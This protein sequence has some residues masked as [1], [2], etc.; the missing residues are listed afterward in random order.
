MKNAKSLTLRLLAMVLAAIC[1]LMVGCKPS[2]KA[3]LEEVYNK[4]V[5]SASAAVKL[6][7]TISSDGTYVT[8]DSNPLNSDDY[9]VPG[10]YDAL[11]LFKTEME[12]PEY[13]DE[14]I[15]ST[16]WSMGK[17]TEEIGDYILTW[18]YH[19]DKGLELMCRVK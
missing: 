5:N 17:Q 10:F 19:P 18:T 8:A 15:G 2:P 16:T 3:K 9:T 11:D 4:V 1:S 14:A 7:F 13:L 6:C 12:F